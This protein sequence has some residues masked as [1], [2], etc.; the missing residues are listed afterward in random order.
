[1]NDFD[2][3]QTM[4]EEEALESQEDN[5]DEISALNEEQDMPLEELLKLYNYGGGAQPSPPTPSGTR[6][7]RSRAKKR[8]NREQA[9]SKKQDRD[10]D[11]AEE[12]LEKQMKEQ[13]QTENGVSRYSIFFLVL[14]LNLG[15]YHSKLQKISLFGRNGRI[16]LMIVKKEW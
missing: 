13:E 14:K 15:L 8:K 5:D 6:K 11:D 12:P 4:E 16:R 1:M 10:D 3:E 7:E 2:D 9:D